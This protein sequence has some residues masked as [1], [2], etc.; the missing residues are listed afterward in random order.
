MSQ[1]ANPLKQYFRQPS[2]YLRLPSEG[3]FWPAGSINMPPNKELPVLPMTAIDE[4]TYRTPD[5]LF[6][7]S[8][9]VNVIQSCIPNIKDAWASPGT[10]LNSMLVA[11]R[12]ASYGHDMEINS[13]CPEC[14]N[15]DEYTIDLRLVLDGLQMAD[16][17]TPLQEGD[18]EI[19]FQPMSYRD[20]NDV[21]VKQFEEQRIL[22][23]VPDSVLPDEQKLELLNQ[24]LQKIT[25]LTVSTLKWNIASIRTPQVLVTDPAHIEEFLRNAD[26]KL[27]IKI[28]DLIIEKRSVSEFKPVQIACANCGHEYKQSVTLDQTSFFDQA[29]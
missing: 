12:I 7:G 26:R 25:Q 9:V 6:N 4:I 13:Q 10:D 8:A 24:A 15:E 22:Q 21:N 18:L 19:A 29:S 23:T 17:S 3:N 11:I 20:Q 2:V 1:N 28:R 27:F 14:K 5:A 16:Y